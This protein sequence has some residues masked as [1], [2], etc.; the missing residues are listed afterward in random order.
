MCHRYLAK[1]DLNGTWSVREA[2]TNY[3]AISIGRRLAGMTEQNA[4]LTAREFYSWDD[5]SRTG[6]VPSRIFKSWRSDK[7][8]PECPAVSF[9]GTD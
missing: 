4:V 2:D 7:P 5:L 1:R 9:N 3:L 8:T 6:D